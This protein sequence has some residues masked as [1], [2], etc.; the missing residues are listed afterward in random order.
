MYP[1]RSNY[2]LQVLQPP[3]FFQKMQCSYRCNLLLLYDSNS[4]CD[5]CGKDEPEDSSHAVI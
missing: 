2:M 1:F 5:V 4:L 3:F